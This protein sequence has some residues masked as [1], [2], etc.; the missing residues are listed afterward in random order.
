MFDAVKA[1]SNPDEIVAAPKARAMVLE[2]GRPAIQVDDYRPIPSDVDVGLIVAE[3]DSRVDAA[4]SVNPEQFTEVW[5]N[6]RFV[7][8]RP[9]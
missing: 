9:V 3:R 5:R 2:T 1:L 4:L 6:P 8:Y 7:I